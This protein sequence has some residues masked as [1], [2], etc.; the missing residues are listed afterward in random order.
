MTNL[1]KFALLGA[2]AFAAPQTADAKEFKYN[3][4]RTISSG[5]FD[6]DTSFFWVKE[7]PAGGCYQDDYFT[8]KVKKKPKHGTFTATRTIK[9][10]TSGP[11]AGIAVNAYQFYYQ[12][13]RRPKNDK[14]VLEIGSIDRLPNRKDVDRARIEIKIKKK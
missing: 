3:W 9:V 12:P 13:K 14:L 11:C 4:K 7:N 8:V 1:F 5:N 2:L 10:L 6:Q